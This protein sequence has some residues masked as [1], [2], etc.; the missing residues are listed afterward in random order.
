MNKLK[1]AKFKAFETQ[2][3]IP[4]S[5]KSN[6]LLYGENG[7]GKSSVYD[8]IKVTFFRNKIESSLSAQTPED[9]IQL[10][11]ELWGSYNNK[12]HNQ[13]FEIEIDG[14]DYKDFNN[15][16]YEVFMISVE[17]LFVESKIS[18]ERLLS[19]CYFSID[20]INE[21]CTNYHQ[22]IQ[23]EVNN[24]LATFNENVTIEIDEEDNYT[25]KIIDNRKN[26][27]RKSEVRKYFNEAKL[28]LITILIL[29]NVAVKS[30]TAQKSK[31]LVLDDFISS[32]DA[33]N[34]TFLIKYVLERFQDTQI[35]V[36][37]HN[38]SF[39]N[40]IMY[41]VHDIDNTATRW[42]FAN[43]YE[44][45]NVHKIY[46]KSEVQRVKDI[47]DAFKALALPTTTA[48]I[49]GIGNKI[50]KKFEVL[51]YEYS[52]LLMIGAVEDSSKIL[53]RITQGK[54]AYYKDKNTA[55]DLVDALQKILDENNPNSLTVRLQSKIDSYKNV[56]FGNFQKI[57]KELKLY[58]KVSMH[59]LSHG[60][61]GI[62]T[63]TVKEIEK[64]IQLLEKMEGFL[65]D[66]V[67]S[68]VA[69]I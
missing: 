30:K 42:T 43:V 56:E 65:K 37:T 51:L 8:A 69:T 20:D 49:E 29:L 64:S 34:R 55:S 53:E 19:R 68:N 23:D 33:S 32:L 24:A 62:P 13:D 28:N 22:Y 45:D 58:Q 16:A 2:I 4:L 47:N 52:K 61:N 31:I 50:R 63:F 3:E 1:I 46:I 41:V 48:D 18:L 57:L 59:P 54:S 7:A 9:L 14:Q 60:V 15:T 27:E 44:I 21:L 67:N 11:N 36:F 35:L 17:E 25:V 39:Y 12:I 10:K 5:G 66:M 26:I 6:L 40:L 38:I